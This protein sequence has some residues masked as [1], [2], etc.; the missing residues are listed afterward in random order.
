MFRLMISR[1][2]FLTG[3]IIGVIGTRYISKKVK[4]F[5]DGKVT[6]VQLI[7]EEV[8]SSNTEDTVEKKEES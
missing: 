7:L 2:P 5:V 3:V 6:I 8:D 1:R 4:K